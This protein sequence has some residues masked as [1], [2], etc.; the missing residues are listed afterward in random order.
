[1]SFRTYRRLGVVGLAC[2]G[3]GAGAGAIANAGA[4]SQAV[5][6]HH[7]RQRTLLSRAVHGD[8]VVHTRAGFVTVTFD[9]GVVKSVSGQQLTLTE[10][11]R[12]ATYKTVTLTIPADARIRDN[13]RKATLSDVKPGQRAVVVQWPQRTVVVARDPRKNG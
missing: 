5:P 6:K 7:K 1:M 2:A 3:L 10:G 8:A 9:R 12:K 13:R 4:S 11:T